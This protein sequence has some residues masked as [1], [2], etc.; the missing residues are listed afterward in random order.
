MEGLTSH[1][2]GSLILT[3]SNPQHALTSYD[4]EWDVAELEEKFRW[5]KHQ[6]SERCAGRPQE[7]AT[8]Q[9]RRRTAELTL[10]VSPLSFFLVPLSVLCS[11]HRMTDT[12]AP[13][14]PPAGGEEDRETERY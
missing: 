9:A 2:K 13:S 5:G 6:R 3:F 4:G 11:T 8:H 10:S 7:A 14:L 1:N 12:A